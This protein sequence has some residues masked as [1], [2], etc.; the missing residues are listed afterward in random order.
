MKR[1]VFLMFVII[2]L[3]VQVNG[4]P[5][6]MNAFF[7]EDGAYFATV[8]D[9]FNPIAVWDAKTGKPLTY[10]IPDKDAV[11]YN[12]G[13]PKTFFTFDNKIGISASTILKMYTIQNGEVTE[14]ETGSIIDGLYGNDL[15]FNVAKKDS[16][17]K[18]LPNQKIRFLNA[19]TFMDNKWYVFY[20]NDE[21]KVPKSM[22]TVWDINGNMTGK[23]LLLSGRGTYQI[24]IKGSTLAF[25]NMIKSVDD[26]NGIETRTYTYSLY[27]TKS[28][29][30]TLTKNII[31]INDETLGSSFDITEDLKYGAFI[32]RQEEKSD[33]E[34]RVMIVELKTGKIA[35][36]HT[37][38]VQTL[39]FMEGTTVN[40]LVYDKPSGGVYYLGRF[41]ALADDEVTV[42]SPV[43]AS[44]EN[45]ASLPG[46]G[47]WVEKNYEKFL[48]K[49]NIGDLFSKY[50]WKKKQSFEKL[51]VYCSLVSFP[52]NGYKRFLKDYV[53]NALG[54]S[55][56]EVPAFMNYAGV[57]ELIPEIAILREQKNQGQMDAW[58]VKRKEYID[59]F[60]KYKPWIGDF[61]TKESIYHNGSNKSDWWDRK[62]K[63][64][65]YTNLK[66]FINHLTEVTACSEYRQHTKNARDEELDAINEVIADFAFSFGELAL[67]YASY[68]IKE[69]GR[70][71]YAYDLNELRGIAVNYYITAQWT[72]DE[73]RDK[74]AREKANLAERF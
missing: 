18:K 52:E 34:P 14:V 74:E 64:I 55:L 44:R 39:K 67:Q 35:K 65:D 37:Y 26:D 20:D 63:F 4:I 31:L 8:I 17:E 38:D 1:F 6:F 49:P 24:M 27:D 45:F 16:F 57:P 5:Q 54:I 15:F 48:E 66:W 2:S 42:I 30:I 51:K 53:S 58:Y 50:E 3:T 61:I 62:K 71:N 41:D 12:N 22:L 72:R 60:I 40:A 59:E 36:E 11:F 29:K 46:Y 70:E 19:Y 69:Y 13:L 73:A 28:G 47:E 21:P 23:P 33:A 43:S 7:S 10:I 25:F 56:D 68:H 9:E 32:V